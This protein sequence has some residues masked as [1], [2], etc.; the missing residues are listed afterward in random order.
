MPMMGDDPS[1]RF[2]AQQ[3]A[4]RSPRPWSQS[5]RRNQSVAAR[6]GLFEWQSEIGYQQASLLQPH[7]RGL[8]PP[9]QAE[10]VP[11]GGTPHRPERT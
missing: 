3:F 4:K 6:C 8:R 11:R 10:T 9:S 1:G 7:K 5:A 2:S